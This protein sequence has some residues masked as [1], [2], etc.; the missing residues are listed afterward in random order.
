[1]LLGLDKTFIVSCSNEC[2]SIIL[3]SSKEGELESVRHYQDRMVISLKGF[4]N[5]EIVKM[6]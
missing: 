4:D 3:D 6:Y 5:Q 1:M 2:T